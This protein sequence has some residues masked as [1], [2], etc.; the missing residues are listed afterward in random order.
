MSVTA[1]ITSETRRIAGIETFLRRRAG[2]GTPALFVHGN[3]THSGDWMPFLRALDG[4]AIA[5]DLPNFGRSERLDPTRFDASMHAYAEFLGSAMDELAPGRFDLVVHDWGGIALHAAQRRADRVR[6]LVVV[7]AVPLLAGYRWHWI[8]RLWRRRLLGD[9]VN[10]LTTRRLLTLT[11]RQARP[12]FRRMPDEFIEM[13]WSCWDQGTRDAVLSLYRSAD[14]TALEA[15]GSHLD[16]LDGPA[17]VIW[18]QNDPYLGPEQ[19]RAYAARLPGAELVALEHAGHW[20]WIDRP[21]V[22]DRVVDF[23]GS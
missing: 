14:P 10:T 6:R 22:V 3:P 1:P 11:L 15:A 23:L 7:N 16:R 8:A 4:P 2:N 12:R 13:V 18:G 9:W 19:G 17:L 5:P 20:P 21:E